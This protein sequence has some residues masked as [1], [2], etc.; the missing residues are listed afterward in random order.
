MTNYENRTYVGRATLTGDETILTRL[1]AELREAMNMGRRLT[2]IFRDPAPIPTSENETWLTFVRGRVGESKNRLVI[3]YAGA[4]PGSENLWQ[5][6][7]DSFGVSAILEA[8][9]EKT[10]KMALL[11]TV[12]PH[13][14]KAKNPDDILVDE[15]HMPF[16]VRWPETF[17]RGVPGRMMTV[18][19]STRVF[20]HK[21]PAHDPE[22]WDWELLLGYER[23]VELHGTRPLSESE[24]S[25]A[26]TAVECS[27]LHLETLMARATRDVLDIKARSWTRA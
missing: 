10:L 15:D 8:R 24:E 20:I 27:T 2:S 23:R 21:Y 11:S 3:D 19:D 18:N 26:R 12:S 7:C 22:R 5:F 4:T 14:G 13:A 1:E 9:D 25:V 6:L 16:D 17:N